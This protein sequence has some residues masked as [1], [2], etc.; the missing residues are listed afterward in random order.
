MQGILSE[1][2]IESSS[3]ASV[4]FELFICVLSA[5]YTIKRK[6]LLTIDA[7][8][9]TFVNLNVAAPAAVTADGLGSFHVIR[10]WRFPLYRAYSGM[11]DLQEIRR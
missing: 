3:V 8:Y 11:Y 6:V 2:F 9:L 7:Q 1:L 5:S 10:I 4:P